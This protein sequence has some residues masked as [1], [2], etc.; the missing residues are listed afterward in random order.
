M[1]KIMDGKK[2]LP[3]RAPGADERTDFEISWLKK[4]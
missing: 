1:L 4:V 2:V 3:V